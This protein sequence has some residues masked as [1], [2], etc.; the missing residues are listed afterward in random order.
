[1]RNLSQSGILSCMSSTYLNRPSKFIPSWQTASLILLLI[2][3]P[4]F[5]QNKNVPNGFVSLFNGKDFSGWEG[6]LES[7]RIEDG[8]IVGGQLKNR[9]PHNQF[10]ATKKSYKDFILRAKFKLVGNNPNAGIQIRSQRIPNH[11]E[12]IGYQADLGQKYWGSLYDES[13]RRKMIATAKLDEVMKVL[14]PNEW[15]EYKIR[16]VGR[17][18]QLWINGQMTVDYLEEDKSLEQFGLIALQ[19]HSG[20]PS[21]AWYKDVWI[22][23]IK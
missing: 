16:A 3:M 14:K 18:V 13:R 10:L 9:I 4:G 12:M 7:F 15:N 11:H 8:A 2:A 22:K 6:P 5:S 21:E 1:M 23:E 17:R 20:A 19:I